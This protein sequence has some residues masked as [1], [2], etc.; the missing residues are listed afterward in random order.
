VDGVS[1]MDNLNI[2]QLP[3]VNLKGDMVCLTQD[4]FILFPQITQQLTAISP[5]F[6][7]NFIDGL[8]LNGKL[9]LVLKDV[10]QYKI[11][12]QNTFYNYYHVEGVVVFGDVIFCFVDFGKCLVINTLSD[13]VKTIYIDAPATIIHVYQLTTFLFAVITQSPTTV[14]IYSLDDAGAIADATDSSHIT[15]PSYTYG[16]FANP[17]QNPRLVKREDVYYLIGDD[18]T[19]ILDLQVSDILYLR[20]VD[21]FLQRIS[22]FPELEEQGIKF[23]WETKNFLLF[24]NTVF[25]NFVWISKGEDK[26]YFSTNYIYLSSQHA[27][28]D[29]NLYTMRDIISPD[30]DNL[31]IP[32]EFTAKVRMNNLTGLGI[33]ILEATN[34]DVGYMSILSRFLDFENYFNYSVKTTQTNYRLALRGEE[35]VISLYTKEA[36]RI[37][38]FQVW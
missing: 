5:V 13:T 37:R 35:F 19:V 34:E 10:S 4:K 6:Y 33:E 38:G 30:Y 8:V 31:H 11:V 17:K 28:Y 18:A 14:Y 15:L 20:T 9:F 36:C 7:N 16:T 22:P 21:T 24:K 23:L 2:N 3:L 12:Y 32:K 26:V 25:N 27:M 1:D 29:N